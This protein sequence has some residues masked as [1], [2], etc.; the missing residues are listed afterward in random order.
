MALGSRASTVIPVWQK[1]RHIHLHPSTHTIISSSLF[2]TELEG[3]VEG[4][5]DVDLEAEVELRHGCDLCSQ[6]FFLDFSERT[7][8]HGADS[9]P[10]PSD[11]W[12][13]LARRFGDQVEEF[14]S[15]CEPLSFRP[16][17]LVHPSRKRYYTYFDVGF[18]DLNEWARQGCLFSRHLL[19]C[20]ED[21][22][23]VIDETHVLGAKSI[24]MS[25]NL[26]PLSDIHFVVF[27]LATWKELH[28]FGL[29]KNITLFKYTVAETANTQGTAFDGNDC[30]GVRRRNRTPSSRASLKK[31]RHWME[32]CINT[33]TTLPKAR[34]LYT[35]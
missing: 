23:A 3:L 10:K 7:H 1:R 2:A 32:T 35:H 31:A 12:K 18:S 24:V 33:H 16:N 28:G 34:R 11:R 17:W 13:S 20:L 5:A 21:S 19:R 15:F 25:P 26:F 8:N 29:F 14:V 9:G 6:A 22:G 4:M 30:R 27:D